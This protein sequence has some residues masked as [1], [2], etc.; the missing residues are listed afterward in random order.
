MTRTRHLAALAIGTA[1]FTSSCG[2]SLQNAQFG[3]SSGSSSKRITAVFA[4]AGRLP[5]GGTVRIG[6]AAAGRVASIKTKNFQALVELSIDRDIPLAAG[7]TARLELTS[8]LSEEFVTLEP[9]A[10]PNPG[11]QLVDGSVIPLQNTSRGPDMENTL[12]AVGALLNGS[13]IDQARTVVTEL[14]TAMGGREQK[15]R[16]LLNQLQVVLTSL[17]AHSAEVTSVIDSMHAVSGE[18]AQNR[19][20]LESAFTRIRPALDE[21][22]KE[23]DQFSQLLGNT[24]SLSTTTNGLVRQTDDQLIKQVHQLRPVLDDLRKFD[25]SLGTTLASMHTF[26]GLFQQATPGDYTRFNGTIDVPGTVRELL[27]PQAVAPPPLPGPADQV[28]KDGTR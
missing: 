16:D 14:N 19:P 15:L 1:V 11:P 10:Q 22:L 18:L 4:D 13:G 20:I 5:L 9:P 24:A 27:N 25:G 17:E 3:A 2:F 8:P 6:Q 28:L 12:A 26:S 21:L 7:T 23:R